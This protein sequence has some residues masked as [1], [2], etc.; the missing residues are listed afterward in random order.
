MHR[1]LFGSYFFYVFLDGTNPQKIETNSV[2][3]NEKKWFRSTAN[4]STGTE[5]LK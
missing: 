1:S 5:K 2:V 4:S 3:L